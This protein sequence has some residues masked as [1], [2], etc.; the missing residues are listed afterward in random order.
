MPRLLHHLAQEDHGLHKLLVGDQ[1]APAENV[2][3]DPYENVVLPDR[4]IPLIGESESAVVQDLIEFCH[5]L[6]CLLQSLHTHGAIS[7]ES[8]TY[9]MC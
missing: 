5:Q 4:Q 8:F 9:A 6:H 1:E 3:N 7:L 2:E